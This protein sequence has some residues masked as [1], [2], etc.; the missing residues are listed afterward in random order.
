MGTKRCSMCAKEI[1]ENEFALHRRYGKVGR[2]SYCRSCKREYHRRNKKERNEVN[3]RC[4]N[5]RKES[6]M[7]AIIEYLKAHPCVDCK[8]NDPLVLTFDHVR[9]KKWKN[10]GNL[11]AEGYKYETILLEIE[12]CDVRCANCHLRKTTSTRGSRKLRLI[13]LS[14]MPL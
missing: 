4:A 3:R 13:T 5:A 2:Q 14:N 1:S 10:I 11:V 12:K 8:E 9:N 6:S 7:K